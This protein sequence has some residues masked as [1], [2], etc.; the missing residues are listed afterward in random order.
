MMDL[1]EQKT[2]D[3][4][5]IAPNALACDE[6]EL[7]G[8]TLESTETGSEPDWQ[9]RC[10]EA[11][12]ALGDSLEFAAL[13]AAEGG[14]LSAETLRESAV[15]RRFCELRRMGLTVKEAFS[16]ADSARE[17]KSPPAGKEHLLSAPMKQKTSPHRLSGEELA[18]AKQLLGEDYSN[19]ELMKLYRRVAK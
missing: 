12:A 1:D 3:G 19:E 15:Y 7:D 14:E 5:E 6:T 4:E 11:E 18:L 16:A 9:S 2:Q 8:D 13:Y 17:R 10:L